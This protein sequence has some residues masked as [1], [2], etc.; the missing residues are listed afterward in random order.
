MKQTK[1]KLRRYRIVKTKRNKF[2]APMIA[3][4]KFI[5]G[6]DQEIHEDDAI[7]F[8]YKL[9]LGA[10]KR[11]IESYY[12]DIQMYDEENVYLATSSSSGLRGKPYCYQMLAS[13]R[14]QLDKHGLNGKKID[15]EVFSNQFKDAYEKM[16]IFSKNHGIDVLET[17]KPCKDVKCCNYT[18]RFIFRVKLLRGLVMESFKLF[19]GILLTHSFPVTTKVRVTL[20]SKV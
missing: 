10:I 18:N 5:I 15:D 2:L 11:L 3:G 13:T 14:K 16:K 9:P 17:F 6:Y 19:R 7:E 12:K 8:S 4:K 1:P 20:N